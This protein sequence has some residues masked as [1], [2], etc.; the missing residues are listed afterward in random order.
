MMSLER[1]W[2]IGQPGG[3][4]FSSAS[5]SV[6]DAPQYFGI[7]GLFAAVLR[8][9]SADERVFGHLAVQAG[10][11]GVQHGYRP[12]DSAGQYQVRPPR[13]WRTA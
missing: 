4:C 1:R 2:P 10:D 9:E 6:L 11:G 3:L 8:G 12:L 7:T 5:P 13:A